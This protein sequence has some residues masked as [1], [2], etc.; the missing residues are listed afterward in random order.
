MSAHWR[1]SSARTG[2][3]AAATGDVQQEVGDALE[4]AV[5][6]VLGSPGRACRQVVEAAADLRQDER[7][8][9]RAFSEL[10]A[11]LIRRAGT[12]V[13][14]QGLGEGQVRRHPFRLVRA[15]EQGE[16][17]PGARA[18]GQL[19]HQPRLADP[20]LAGDQHD[21]ALAPADGLQAFLQR[22]Q[23]ALSPDER[24]PRATGRPDMAPPCAAMAPG[25]G[26]YGGCRD[27]PARA[28]VMATSGHVVA[29][30]VPR[31]AAVDTVRKI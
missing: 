29:G 2:R 19:E 12:D 17:A 10:R 30:T 14:A 8:V 28:S 6:L 5:A 20:G 11:Q 27:R 16:A 31:T 21:A 4:Q 15:T 25:R 7:H 23:L 9:G 24:R 18:I 13:L 1:S 26:L 22:R 3:P